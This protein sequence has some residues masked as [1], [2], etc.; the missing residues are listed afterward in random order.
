MCS[1]LLDDKIIEKSVTAITS[2]VMG[3]QLRSPSFIC[4]NIGRTS[5]WVGR[6]F[7]C[8]DCVSYPIVYN[9]A[10]FVSEKNEYVW[11]YVVERTTF[12]TSIYSL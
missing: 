3:R 1:R 11:W 10:L 12:R 7:W 5:E 8:W 9:D 2:A 6:M 4:R